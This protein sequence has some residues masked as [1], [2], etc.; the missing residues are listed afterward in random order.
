MKK[1]TYTFTTKEVGI[2]TYYVTIRDA[3]G[4]SLTL[5]YQMNVV[6]NPGLVLKGTIKSSTSST[7][8]EQRAVT[9]DSGDEQRIRGI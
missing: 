5:S 4:K 2:H 3:K 7:Q 9:L 6:M 1:N 8:Y